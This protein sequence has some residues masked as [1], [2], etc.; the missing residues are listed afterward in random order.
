[1]FLIQPSSNV[2][3]RH[4]THDMSLID[5]PASIHAGK[6]FDHYHMYK[7]DI[8]GYMFQASSINKEIV[9]FIQKFKNNTKI[10]LY[11][12][13]FNAQLYNDASSMVRCILREDIVANKQSSL[14]QKNTIKAGI[15][16]SEQLINSV[17]LPD[18]RENT[19]NIIADISDISSLPQ[20]LDSLLYPKTKLKIKLFNN[21]LIGHHQNLGFVDDKQMISMIDTCNIY[22]DTNLNYLLYSVILDKPTI[23]LETNSILKKTKELSEKTLEENIESSK[24]ELD[25]IIKNSYKNFIQKYLL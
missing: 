1:M 9:D 5:Q 8:S 13:K 19:E 11:F 25:S 10:Y 7:K 23:A 4:F 20:Q 2:F 15:M 6:L 16:Y 12:D 17:N 3:T 21:H 14:K 24:I 18:K 22:I